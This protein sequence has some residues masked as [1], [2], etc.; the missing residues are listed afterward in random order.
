M[1]CNYVKVI[2]KNIRDNECYYLICQILMPPYFKYINIY[3]KNILYEQPY[4][5][6]KK[7]R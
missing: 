7:K 3:R 1:S 6:R 4:I 2:K 5:K